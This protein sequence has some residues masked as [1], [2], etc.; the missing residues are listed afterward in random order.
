M[1]L[2]S[3]KITVWGNVD[4]DTPEGE[5]LLEDISAAVELGLEAVKASLVE[6]FAAVGL[7]V[8]IDNT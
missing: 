4:S 1:A 7:V 3:Q 5:A 8:E 6:R 2:T